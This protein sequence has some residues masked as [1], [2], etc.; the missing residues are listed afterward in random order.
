[1]N[2]ANYDSSDFFRLNSSFYRS[3]SG[4]AWFMNAMPATHLSNVRSS[5]FTD[6]NG[7]RIES[8]YMYAY[9][10]G[11]LANPFNVMLFNNVVYFASGTSKSSTPIILAPLGGNATWLVTPTS[12]NW[13]TTPSETNWSSGAGNYPG[14]IASTTNA[15]TAT[16]LTSNTTTINVNTPVNI[17]NITFGVASNTPS[18]FTIGTT[19]GNALL[20]TTG[21]QIQLS[22]SITGTNI[23]ETVNSPLIIE[24][25][26]STQALYSFQNSASDPSNK[27]V[28]N[29]SVTVAGTTSSA[30]TLTLSGANTGANEVTGVISNGAT[31]ALRITKTG[32]GNWAL[33]GATANTYTGRTLVNDGTLILNKAAGVDAISS[34]GGTG[35]SATTTDV[36]ITGTST[37]STIAGGTVRLDASNQIIDTA[38]VSLSGGALRLNGVQE[39]TTANSGVGALTLGSTSVIDLS[40]TSLLHFAASGSKTWSGTLAIWNWSGTLVTGGGSEQLLFGN[41]TTTASLTQAQ[42]NQI[43]FYSDNG[44]T[45]LGTGAWA[46]VGD[47]EVVPIPE[48]STWIGAGLALVAIGFT[49]RRKI[50]GLVTR[51]A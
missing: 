17:K 37:T 28:I 42:L 49:Q 20:L 10:V 22:G 24:G 5:A 15:D 30:S 19:A 8:P 35:T 14:D 36:Q 13:V 46:T 51:A 33:S 29:G 9:E 16:F 6:R 18:S 50:R 23:T 34:T 31:G 21:G 7:D 48:P 44:T 2:L 38:Q 26:G 25:S 40:N 45:F 39:G 1:M 43:S 32:A 41:N 12:A 27:L 3:A 11:T 47:G 4:P